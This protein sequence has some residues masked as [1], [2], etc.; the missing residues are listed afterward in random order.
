MYS[1]S[2]ATV[3]A[4]LFGGLIW[5][6]N[7]RKFI[8]ITG[9]VIFAAIMEG[10]HMLLALIICGPTQQII[11]IIQTLAIPMIV[12]NAAGMFVFAFIIQNLQNER[13]M[14][15]ERDV[16]LREMERKDTELAIAAEI[17]Q[18]FLPDTIRQVE[19]LVSSLPCDQ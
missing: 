7:K 2:L 12:S 8:G 5:L 15:A 13:K 18:S 9:A 17:Q 4:G 11:A 10:I 14:Q 6:A 1:C 19:G 16:L 3:L